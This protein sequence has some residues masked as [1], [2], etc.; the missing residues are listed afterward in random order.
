VR[1][2]KCIAT[3]PGV[4]QDKIIE[5]GNGIT[6]VRGKNNAGKTLLSRALIDAIFPF[7]S[8]KLLEGESWKNISI[9]IDTR[10]DNATYR[11]IR[12]DMNHYSI[13]TVNDRGSVLHSHKL[14]NASN[15]TSDL[16]LELQSKNGFVRLADFYRNIGFQGF[17][18]A[19]YL[20]SAVDIDNLPPVSRD[21]IDFLL[22]QDRSNYYA[23]YTVIRESYSNRDISSKVH[24]ELMN[25][26]FKFERLHKD[27]VKKL[28]LMKINASKREKQQ[29]EL[30]RYNEEIK[31]I[32]SKIDAF[33]IRKNH[34]ARILEACSRKNNLVHDIQD[35]QK[36]IK[37]GIEQEK[38]IAAR[39]K[40]LDK[41]YPQFRN[42]DQAKKNNIKHMQD[43]YREIRAINEKIENELFKRESSVRHVGR[44]LSGINLLIL[45]A[46][47]W[48]FLQTSIMLNRDEKMIIIGSMIIMQLLSYISHIIYRYRLFHSSVLYD[49]EQEKQ[50]L[51]QK[52]E[53]ILRE[54]DID[55]QNIDLEEI[56]EFL[57]QYFEEYGEFNEKQ[58]DLY[59][60]KKTHNEQYINSNLEEKKEA[61]KADLQSLSGTIQEM[62]N[63]A[64]IDTKILN[65]EELLLTMMDETIEKIDSLSSELTAKQKVA[66]SISLNLQKSP[67]ATYEQK[68]LEQ[69]LDEYNKMLD[70]LTRRQKHVKYLLDL[71]DE[72]IQHRMQI[73]MEQLVH[74]TASIFRE[75]TGSSYSQPI[76]MKTIVNV[77]KKKHTDNTV[78]AS[79]S[80][81]LQLAIKCALHDFLVDSGVSIPL[82]LDD[83]IVFI[84]EDKID[85]FRKIIEKTAQSRQVVIFTH[86][87]ALNSWYTPVE[88]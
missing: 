25:Q 51:E 54:N 29:G 22:L 5:L 74:T 48:L 39:E 56:Y 71:F 10:F 64:G 21:A 7:A 8:T 60:L 73:Q 50:D 12:K 67:D 83:P 18:A 69:Q 44:V 72:S 65:N 63:M 27:T 6:V 85:A 15:S 14:S 52:L 84:D 1:I 75:L 19:G 35:I 46:V 47:V 30:A 41:L 45:T 80:H 86:S 23:T 59:M 77:M 82:I 13:N 31:S 37:T 66:D 87:N 43:R 36:K 58:L 53:N 33:S 38:E 40:E 70:T 62:A 61:L 20:P 79:F 28:E 26:I 68:H 49:L 24:N 78:N 57:L 81:L 3:C 55:M 88:L 4:F 42:F 34:I 16:V 17:I 76:D 9:E 32:S 11:F 2:K